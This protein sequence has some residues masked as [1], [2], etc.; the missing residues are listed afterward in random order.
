MMGPKASEDVL[1]VRGG[2]LHVHEA[3]E[4]LGVS[5]YTVRSW[6]RSR[7]LGHIRLG[8]RVLVPEDELHRLIE[9]GRVEA[10]LR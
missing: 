8:R 6:L 9:A 10:R 5:I 2:L 4:R 1:S 3:A 7:R